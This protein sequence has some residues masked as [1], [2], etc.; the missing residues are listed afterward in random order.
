MTDHIVVGID[1]TAGSKAALAWALREAEMRNTSLEA[2]YVYLEDDYSDHDV[3]A[4]KMAGIVEA[5]KTETG[6]TIDATV[7]IVFGESAPHGLVHASREAELLV[8]GVSGHLSIIDRM[9]GSVSSACAHQAH[10]TVVIVRSN[11]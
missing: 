11:P 6:S 2:V 1:D 5:V 8:V 10:C 9:L 7:T 4:A 3:V